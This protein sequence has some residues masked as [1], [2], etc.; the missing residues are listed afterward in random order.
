MKTPFF[1]NRKAW[2]WLLGIGI[3]L[4]VASALVF[5]LVP[6][7]NTLTFHSLAYG[8]AAEYLIYGLVI[9]IPVV[10]FS[11]LFGVALGSAIRKKEW[12][13]ERPRSRVWQVFLILWV[14]FFGLYCG[15]Y[16]YMLPRAIGFETYQVPMS[17]GTR[18]NTVVYRQNPWETRPVLLMRTPYGSI[19][20]K[21]AVDDY[22]E[23]GF[24]VVV[25]DCRG[26][27]PV[28]PGIIDEHLSGGT[29]VPFIHDVLD[30][31]DTINWIAAQPWCD[32]RVFMAGGSYL[33]WTQLAAAIARPKALKAITPIVFGSTPY[34]AAYCN[35]MFQQNLAGTWLLLMSECHGN[36]VNAL[37]DFAPP[38]SALDDLGCAGGFEYW[39]RSLNESLP[40]MFWQLE[41][42]LHG[43]D[44]VEVPVYQE[45]GYFDY[46]AWNGI[47]D[48][49]QLSAR[50]DF[51]ANHSILVIGPHGHGSV[52]QSLSAAEPLARNYPDREAR[53]FLVAAASGTLPAKQ[54]RAY[55]IGA[56]TWVNGT[57]WPLAGTTNTTYYLRA[58]GALDVTPPAGAEPADTYTYNPLTTLNYMNAGLAWGEWEDHAV[59]TTQNDSLVYELPV[60]G[61]GLALCGQIGIHL[62]ATSNCTDTDWVVEVLDHDPATNTSMFLCHGMMRAAARNAGSALEYLTPGQSYGYT[63]DSWPIGAYF[64]PGH[65]LQL[66]IRSSKYPYYAKNFN[67]QNTYFNSTWAV[68]SNSIHHSAANPSYVT[69]PVIALP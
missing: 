3:A 68:A 67:V 28:I 41:G 20:S 48:F 15:A 1:R 25:Q 52:P 9:G 60:G 21:G 43:M 40:S 6:Q 66:V 30:G 58:G 51:A 11:I 18:L 37:A 36:G 35:G 47:R 13:F 24:H 65:V 33:A 10:L 59:I 8:V 61:G 4:G 39:D 57:S 34:D 62:N 69:L 56:N 29:F 46:F 50:S 2:M 44:R 32:G 64:K 22:V 31:N 49:K 26:T 45:L 5:F 63:F 12:T 27:P 38:L 55:I 23:L 17:D 42:V 54:V 7:V 14:V 53:A 16:L 19:L